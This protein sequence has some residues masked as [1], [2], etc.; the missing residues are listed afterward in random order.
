MNTSRLK[1]EWRFIVYK[2]Q[3]NVAALE[4]KNRISGYITRRE[5]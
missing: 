3:H 5:T 1:I 2:H 4:E